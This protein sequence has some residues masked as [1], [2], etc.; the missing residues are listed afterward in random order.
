MSV[1]TPLRADVFNMICI[2][3]FISYIAYT[4]Y[5]RFLGQH[6]ISKKYILWHVILMPTAFLTI[7][8]E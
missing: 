7:D 1:A 8:F 6:I 4:K 3:L 5:F 2:F